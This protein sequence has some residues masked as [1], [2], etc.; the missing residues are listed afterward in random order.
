MNLGQCMRVSIPGPIQALCR[1]L[2]I[3]GLRIFAAATERQIVHF[4]HISKTGGT[5]V[6]WALRRNVILPDYVILLHGHKTTLADVQPGESVIFCVRDPIQ[7]FIS[8]FYSRW[9][10]GRPRH[11]S[12]WTRSEREA[13]ARF[14]HPT[15]LAEALYAHEDEIRNAALEAMASIKHVNT[16]FWDWLIDE[17]HLKRHKS[18]VLTVARQEHLS[19]DFEEMK[20]I[21]GIQEDISLPSDPIKSHR[22]PASL[23]RH[24]TALA[25]DNLR[26]WYDQDFACLKVCEQLG[27]LPQGSYPLPAPLTRSDDARHITVNQ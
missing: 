26:Q 3:M 6:K 13:F 14:T 1:D 22:S 19:Q 11:Y 20:R 7:R 24:L 25:I 5:A 2:E 4:L 16:S 15:Q 8:G 12:P 21:L 10:K 17:A 9:R 23:D 27:L 18:N